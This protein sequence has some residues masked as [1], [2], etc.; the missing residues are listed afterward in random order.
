MNTNGKIP[1]INMIIACKVLKTK[2]LNIKSSSRKY[3]G[4]TFLLA[5]V[6]TCIRRLYLRKEEANAV[7]ILIF[8]NV[9]KICHVLMTTNRFNE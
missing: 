4:K 1:R 2:L 6:Y 3:V 9:P 7:I 5:Y 8:K